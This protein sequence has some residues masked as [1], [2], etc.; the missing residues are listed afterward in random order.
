M[1]YAPYLFEKTT[2]T[3]TIWE[4]KA[5]S[6]LLQKR[7]TQTRCAADEQ[8]RKH[9]NITKCY[10]ET[11]KGNWLWDST[12]TIWGR[13][14]GGVATDWPLS[15]IGYEESGKMAVRNMINSM[16]QNLWFDRFTRSIQNR[17]VMI[18][19]TLGLY[20]FYQLDIH[21][22][23][24]GYADVHS[25]INVYPMSITN[26]N[27]Q[28]FGYFCMALLTLVLLVMAWKIMRRV[29]LRSFTE[30]WFLQRVLFILLCLVSL[31]MQV[32]D[33][34]VVG[35]YLNGGELHAGMM[36]E[37]PYGIRTDPSKQIFGVAMFLLLIRVGYIFYQLIN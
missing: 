33:I 23:I 4:L 34:V 37:V 17:F 30:L 28:Y 12:S 7:A 20:A 22:P 14:N 25:T 24:A 1:T 19:K 21:I 5:N 10:S 13:Y 9:T 15:A 26:T 35:K 16:K 32:Y 11:S 8:L 2:T 29:T 18:D 27:L 3:N 6:P 31:T 36:G